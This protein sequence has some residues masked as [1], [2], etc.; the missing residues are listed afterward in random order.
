M[1]H[2]ICNFSNY[3]PWEKFLNMGEFTGY[4]YIVCINMA[5]QSKQEVILKKKK[6]HMMKS[7]PCWLKS[8]IESL[9]FIEMEWI[10]EW[11]ATVKNAFA[12]NVYRDLHFKEHI[13]GVP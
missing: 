4:A 7:K 10:H 5:L 11:E 9:L 13:F 12:S 3:P 1:L 6:Q 8:G 2:F